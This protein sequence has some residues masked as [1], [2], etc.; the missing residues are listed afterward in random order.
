MLLHTRK[1]LLEN[2]VNKVEGRKNHYLQIL[3][4]NAVHKVEGRNTSGTK[5]HYHF[6]KI[7]KRNYQ[8]IVL[9]VVGAGR[10]TYNYE[11]QWEGFAR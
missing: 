3:L 9:A 6:T 8:D 5:N 1:N 4:E 7:N 10:N 11:T 2:V